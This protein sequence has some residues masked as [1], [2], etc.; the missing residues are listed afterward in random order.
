MIWKELNN[1]GY[2]K[3]FIKIEKYNLKYLQSH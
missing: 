1:L 2:N 3:F